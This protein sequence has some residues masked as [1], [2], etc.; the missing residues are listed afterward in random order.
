[1][2][3]IYT[4]YIVWNIIVFLL[5]GMDKRK[6]IKGKWRTK[7]KTLI[8]SAFLMG[9]IGA[10]FGMKIFRHKT[11][12]IKFKILIPLAIIFNIAIIFLYYRGVNNAVFQ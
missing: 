10:G 12:H 2:E 5:Y 1:M 8:L 11:K 4:I 7:E 3:I 6:S 9:G